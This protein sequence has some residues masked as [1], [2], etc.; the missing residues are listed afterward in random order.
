MWADVE[1][2]GI[3]PETVQAF[4]F[5]PNLMSWSEKRDCRRANFDR[6]V[7]LNGNPYNFPIVDGIVSPKKYNV[8][9][10]KDGQRVKLD[11]MIDRP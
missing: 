2:R 6:S 1:A 3:D 9:I 8:V 5:D 4:S 10:L 11:P 7:G